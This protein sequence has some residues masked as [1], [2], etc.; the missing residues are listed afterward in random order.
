MHTDEQHKSSENRPEPPESAGFRA[1]LGAIVSA[2]AA[3][4]RDVLGGD[5]LSAPAGEA[6]SGSRLSADCDAGGSDARSSDAPSTAETSRQTVELTVSRTGGRL[7]LSDGEEAY[8]ESDTWDEAE[9]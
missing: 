5:S 3:R 1:R 7:R 6:G 9:R 4:L 8:I 2:A